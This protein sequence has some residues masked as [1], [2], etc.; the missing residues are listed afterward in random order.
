MGLT[1]GNTYSIGETLAE[2]TSGNFDTFGMMIFGMAGS[3]GVNLSEGFQVVKSKIVAK[4]V[5]EDVLEC[6]T[7]DPIQ[8]AFASVIWLFDQ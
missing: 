8:I 2:R 5:K 6:A 7:N 3:L 1:H 4:K